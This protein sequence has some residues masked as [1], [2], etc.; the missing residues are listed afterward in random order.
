[1]GLF[2]IKSKLS[3]KHHLEASLDLKSNM[4]RAV[5]QLKQEDVAFY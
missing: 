2:I 1:M 5:F 3:G 4:N